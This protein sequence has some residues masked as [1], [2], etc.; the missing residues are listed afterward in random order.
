[1]GNSFK[2]NLKEILE[3][4]DMTVK[5]LAFLTGISNRSI[6]NYLN[7]RESMPPADYACKI[8]KALN[9]T[10]EF[11]LTGKDS[12]NHTQVFSKTLSTIISN[13]PK[14]SQ[15]DQM[16]VSQLTVSLSKMK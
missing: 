14:L 12:D 8:A 4:K 16:L 10:V 15:E 11:L 7:A 2:E 3:Y 9:T 5:E 13:F 1:M 6:G